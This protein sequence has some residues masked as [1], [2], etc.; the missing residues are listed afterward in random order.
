MTC[1]CIGPPGACPCMTRAT[2]WDPFLGSVMPEN[3]I[4]NFLP[5]PEPTPLWFWDDALKP[6]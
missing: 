2:T 4:R 1:F 6:E 3:W 5:E